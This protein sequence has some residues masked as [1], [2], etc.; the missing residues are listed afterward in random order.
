MFPY[1]LKVVRELSE[2]RRI[3]LTFYN[4]NPEMFEEN[5]RFAEGLVTF[6][7]SLFY[8]TNQQ[9]GENPDQFC[10][11][12]MNRRLSLSCGI[13]WTRISALYFSMLVMQVFQ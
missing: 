12:F 6:D 4:T 8:L 2:D 5:V 7:E 9:A 13:S 11:R 3:R 10:Q 1:K